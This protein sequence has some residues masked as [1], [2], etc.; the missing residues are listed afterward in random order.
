[1][2]ELKTNKTFAL[3]GGATKDSTLAQVMTKSTS[4]DSEK[5]YS[6]SASPFNSMTPEILHEII[7]CL[8]YSDLQSFVR[9]GLYDRPLQGV[10]SFWKRKLQT[11]M[12]WLWDLPS[13]EQELNWFLVYRE[14]RRQCFP[15][16]VVFDPR[17]DGT[18]RRLLDITS[19][20]RDHS[21]VLGLANRRRIWQTCEQLIKAYLQEVNRRDH[22]VEGEIEKNSIATATK[23]VAHPVEK[24]AHSLKTCFLRSCT[25]EATLE[26]DNEFVLYFQ[27][28]GR[29]SGIKMVMEDESSG[30][31]FGAETD[32]MESVLIPKS[33]WVSHFEVILSG[34]DSVEKEAKVGICGMAV[35]LVVR[36]F[37]FETA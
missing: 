18:D 4:S 7:L 22:G 14:F 26:W 30:E 10:H 36:P 6:A 33:T 20:R 27:E 16:T 13:P 3:S 37:F 24:K 28:D 15:G 1:M 9:S 32:K 29:L 12:P 34:T 8:P 5:H 21:L 31:V 11:D 17:L 19:I 35:S 2:D 23:L 25:W